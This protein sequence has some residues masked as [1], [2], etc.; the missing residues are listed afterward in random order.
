MVCNITCI[1]HREAGGVEYNMIIQYRTEKPYLWNFSTSFPVQF[2]FLAYRKLLWCPTQLYGHEH[3][4]PLE[5]ASRLAEVVVACLEY[6]NIGVSHNFYIML[7]APKSLACLK[8]AMLFGTDF[9]DHSIIPKEIPHVS[10]LL[11]YSTHSC[12]PSHKN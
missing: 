11:L 6:K 9:P 8:S 3:F 2:W 10:L 7:E 12:A 5:T 1:F 4:L